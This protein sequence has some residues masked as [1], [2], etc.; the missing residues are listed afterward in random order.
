MY[1]VFQSGS[2][3][4]RTTDPK[5]TLDSITHKPMI[6]TFEND[7]HDGYRRVDWRTTRKFQNQQANVKFKN[8]IKG[9]M[10]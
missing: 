1:A 5:V 10:R 3:M 6:D 2:K 4:H 7:G 8:R 9:S